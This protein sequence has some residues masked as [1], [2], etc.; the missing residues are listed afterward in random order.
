MYVIPHVIATEA[1]VAYITLAIFFSVILI[2]QILV[3]PYVHEYE[4]RVEEIALGSLIVIL[5]IRASNVFYSYYNF[6]KFLWQK[7]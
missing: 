2:I 5:G 6:C 4:N 1:S 3:Q 7:N